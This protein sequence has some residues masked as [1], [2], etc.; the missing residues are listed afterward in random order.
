MLQS[1]NT[2]FVQNEASL[3]LMQKHGYMQ[4]KLA[5]DTRFDRVQ[6]VAAQQRSI[7]EIETFTQG[8]NVIVAGS[9]WPGDE[10]ILSHAMYHSLVYLNFK[11]IL[12]PHHIDDRSLRRTMRKFKKYS[13]HWSEISTLT[14]EQL[15]ARR[16]LIMDNMGMLP[17]LYRYG[18]VNYVGGGFNRGVHNTLEAAVYGKPVIIGPKFKQF[19]E[20][21]DLVKQ[22]AALDITSEDDLLNRIN[23][24]NQFPFILKGAGD[25]A[26]RYVQEHTGGTNTILQAIRGYLG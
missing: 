4:G 9:T 23:L 7:P 2:V 15:I 24:M 18:D 10:R 1:F 13:I 21:V 14:E 19:P 11:L 25:M 12:A 6:A 3:E 16:I 22:N 17:Y 8:F 26:A 5:F 20:A